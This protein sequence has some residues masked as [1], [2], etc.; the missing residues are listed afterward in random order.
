M[1][2][3]QSPFAAVAVADNCLMHLDVLESERLD[4]GQLTLV[5]CHPCNVDNLDSLLVVLASF[6]LNDRSAKREVMKIIYVK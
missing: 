5:A 3:H 1:D 2:V 4:I 6:R